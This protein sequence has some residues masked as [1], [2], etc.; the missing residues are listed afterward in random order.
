MDASALQVEVT[1]AS[2]VEANAEDTRVTVVLGAE[3]FA[4][5]DS[6]AIHVKNV[7]HQ[8]ALAEREAQER[9]SRVET[10]NAM[11]LDST[12]DDAGGLAR[13]IALLE[14]E[15]V[16]VRQAREVAEEK[17]RGLSDVAANTEHQW[18]EFEK[19]CQKNFEE[20]TLL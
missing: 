13:K 20:L 15:L 16:D 11:T 19:G 4:T 6:T 1:Q 9:V 12:H 8:T 17:S 18:E 10:E 3:N 2:E 7:K 5:W 14:S